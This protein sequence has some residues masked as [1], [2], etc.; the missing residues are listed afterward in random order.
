MLVLR[1]YREVRE[2]HHEDED[3]VDRQRLLDHV[4]GEKLERDTPRFGVRVKPR[5]RHQTRVL[6]ELP[7]RVLV[8]KIVE[9][10][11]ERDPN[12]AP[13]RCFTKADGVRFAVKDAEI[14]GEENENEPNQSRGEPPV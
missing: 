1:R 10:Q 14:D 5:Y 9:D 6:R 8:K 7:E 4:A 11:R 13:R 12:D 2:D 3:V